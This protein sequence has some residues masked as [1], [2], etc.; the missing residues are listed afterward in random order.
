MVDG[1]VN[2]TGALV[3]VSGEVVRTVQTGEIRSYLLLM[4][5]GMVAIVGIYLVL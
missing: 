2:G 1:T 3:E 5:L 4:F